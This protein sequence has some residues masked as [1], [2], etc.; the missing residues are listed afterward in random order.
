MFLSLR[1]IKPVIQRRRNRGR[2]YAMRNNLVAVTLVSRNGRSSP[3][4]PSAKPLEIGFIDYCLDVPT[5]P[6]LS[7]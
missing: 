1:S 5:Y 4:R 7:D 2:G 3:L 6:I